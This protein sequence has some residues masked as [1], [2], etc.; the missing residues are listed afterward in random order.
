MHIMTS[1][2]GHVHIYEQNLKKNVQTGMQVVDWL[3]AHATYAAD[4]GS[5]PGQWTFAAC[6]TPLSLQFPDYPGSNEGAYVWKKSLK[7]KSTNIL[8]S[9]KNNSVDVVSQ[10]YPCCVAEMSSWVSML[11]S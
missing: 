5:N 6:H 8:K 4:P 1:K 2:G 3:R 7:K 9:V 11:T 10:V